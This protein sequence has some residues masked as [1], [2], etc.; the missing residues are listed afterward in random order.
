M[1]TQLL[2]RDPPTPLPVSA[3]FYV[4]ALQNKSGELDALRH[5]SAETWER[6]IPLLH[7]VGPKTRRRPLQAPTVRSWVARAGSALG[8]HPFYLDLLRLASRS[9]VVVAKK[10]VPVLEVIYAAA[11]KR[12]LR[13]VPV[14][15]P[16]DDAAHVNAVANAAIEDGNGLAIRYSLLGTA[17]L[18]G[19]SHQQRAS[20]LLEMLGCDATTCDLIL[21]LGYL[22]PDVELAA[23]DLAPSVRELM[24]AATWR[25]VVLLGSSIP[26]TLSSITED[27]VGSLS[28][29]EWGLWHQLGQLDLPRRPAFGDYAVQHPTPPQDSGPGMRA[30]IRYT[31]DDD[32]LVA[33]GRSILTEG[34]EQYHD[35]CQW[36]VER[37]EFAGSS[38]SWGDAAIDDCARHRRSAGSQHDW[39][40]A[41]TSH[42]LQFVTDQLR[43]LQDDS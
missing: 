2:H 36:L 23:A 27:T 28:R 3:E 42:H 39:R 12:G 31:T 1:Q 13:F 43:A 19:T 32:I 41:G 15:R 9:P 22:D 8:T 38:Y 33:R 34:S 37:D 6:L 5:A 14:V 25:G 26:K 4:A 29:R 10:Q 18:P 20:D 16:D 11:R 35:L 24:S 30:N 7:F 17:L 21:D 40:G